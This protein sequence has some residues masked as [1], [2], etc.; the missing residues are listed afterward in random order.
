MK[1]EAA[2]I[3]DGGNDVVINAKG[4]SA[5]EEQEEEGDILVHTLYVSLSHYVSFGLY[6]I[7]LSQ[8]DLPL[9]YHIISHHTVYHIR[10]DLM[11]QI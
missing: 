8:P 3:V 4:G 6:D 1:A 11:S 5:K 7:D 9:S 10:L 2:V